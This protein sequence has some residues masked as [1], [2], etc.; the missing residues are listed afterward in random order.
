[1]ISTRKPLMTQAVEFQEDVLHYTSVDRV[2][3]PYGKHL[4]SLGDS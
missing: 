4:V 1:M 3:T 2:V